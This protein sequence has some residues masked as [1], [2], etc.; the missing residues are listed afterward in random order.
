MIK[1]CNRC[2]K[3]LQ[4]LDN[5]FNDFTYLICPACRTRFTDEKYITVQELIDQGYIKYERAE[6]KKAHYIREHFILNNEDEKY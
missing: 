4:Y 2:N 6:E 5:E 3:F 1:K